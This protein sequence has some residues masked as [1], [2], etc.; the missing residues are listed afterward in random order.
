MTTRFTAQA[1][2]VDV[3]ADIG[4]FA[5]I[6]S[7]ND[8]GSGRRLE[9]QQP[10][11]PGPYCVC[12]ESGATHYGGVAS[13]SVEGATVKLQLDAEATRVLVTPGF[14]ISVPPQSTERIRQG[15]ERVLGKR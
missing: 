4:V 14:E 6:L 8:D 3:L 5:V 13:W 12:V 15:L 11:E 2:S 9:V 1:V 10:F 7:E